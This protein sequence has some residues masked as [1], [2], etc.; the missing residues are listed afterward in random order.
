MQK[1]LSLLLVI[2]MVVSM[3]VGCAPKTAEEIKSAAEPTKSDSSETE[4]SEEAVDLPVIRVAVMPYYLS[5]PIGYMIDNKLDEAAGFKIEPVMFASGG[6]IN[7]ALPSDEFDISPTGGAWLFGVANYGA[8]AVG[9]HIAATGG[10]SLWVRKDSDIAKVIGHNPDYPEILGDPASLQGVKILQTSGTTGQLMTEKWLGALGVKTS[11]VEPIH[12]DFAQVY[13]AFKTGEGDVAALVQ[14]YSSQ[15][16]DDWVMVA[17]LYQL[18]TPLYETII[19]PKEKYE[20]PEMFELGAKFLRA[21]YGTYDILEAD[22]DE[23]IAAVSKWYADNG[24]ETEIEVVKAECEAKPLITSDEA[25]Q[26]EIGAYEL[27]MARF[28]VSVGKLEE[29]KLKGMADKMGQA[30]LDAAF[31]E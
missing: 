8:Y 24:N 16:Q 20:D 31:D 30:I 22:Y 18:K 1:M 5:A 25:R 9:S 28:F 11:E 4:A 6:P 12:M 10:N 15:T 14:P 23:K 13:Q 7:E 29:S 3:G 2:V 17:D 27:D 21:L 19:M 26:L